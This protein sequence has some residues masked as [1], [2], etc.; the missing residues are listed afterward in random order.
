MIFAETTFCHLVNLDHVDQLGSA[1]NGLP[2]F[3]QSALQSSRGKYRVYLGVDSFCLQNA[4]AGM[5]F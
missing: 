2:N 1:W 3:F 4:G 5:I